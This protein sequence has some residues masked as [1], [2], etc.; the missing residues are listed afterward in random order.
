MNQFVL[1]FAA[2][3]TSHFCLAEQSNH[4]VKIA[5]DETPSIISR[6]QSSAVPTE[7]EAIETWGAEV[8]GNHLT[9]NAKIKI[10]NSGATHTAD[11]QYTV[12]IATRTASSSFTEVVPAMTEGTYQFN[13][14]LEKFDLS[15]L[16]SKSAPFHTIDEVTAAS[17]VKIKLSQKGY[18]NFA[19]THTVN[20]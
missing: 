4:L 20:P 1:M 15:I 11:V 14:P 13:I 6:L 8:K 18:P 7:V 16:K 3:F 19:K 17:G 9:F 10:E 12:A 2:I 5:T